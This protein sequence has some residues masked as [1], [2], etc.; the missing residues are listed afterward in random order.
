M[1]TTLL[2]GLIVL[3]STMGKS[4]PLAEQNDTLSTHVKSTFTLSMP[5]P[6]PVNN[7]LIFNYKAPT[8]TKIASI[9]LFDL[10]GKKIEQFPV[11]GL[12]GQIK[13]NLENYSNGI[14]FYTFYAD[15]IALKTGRFIK[16]TS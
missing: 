16:R 11:E 13:I 12:S 15:D 2:I 4:N 3:I 7:Q 6:N 10:T 5:Y 14:Y 8:Q 1:K 9:H